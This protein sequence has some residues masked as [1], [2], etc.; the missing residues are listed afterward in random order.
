MRC[1]TKGPSIPSGWFAGA[2]SKQSDPGEIEQIDCFDDEP[3]R[4]RARSGEPLTKFRSWAKQFYT[5]PLAG[6]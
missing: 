5:T 1:E 3:V 6:E 2:G 4:F